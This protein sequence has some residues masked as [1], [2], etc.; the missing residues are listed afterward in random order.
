MAEKSPKI[1]RV[2]DDS[3]SVIEIRCY[4]KDEFTIKCFNKYIVNNL[5]GKSFTEITPFGADR[6]D[7][8][9]AINGED[10]RQ[11]DDTELKNLLKQKKGK[12]DKLWQI[13]FLKRSSSQW[14][15]L[16]LQEKV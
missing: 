4:K 9:I 13:R 11:M 10:V 1:Q 2:S 14:S 3:K 6:H 7:V 16:L 15:E 12:F 5:N 8:I